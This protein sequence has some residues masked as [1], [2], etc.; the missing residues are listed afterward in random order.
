MKIWGVLLLGAPVKG[1]CRSCLEGSRKLR[2]YI[3]GFGCTVHSLRHVIC[4]F[5]AIDR[6][7]LLP[8]RGIETRNRIRATALELRAGF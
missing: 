7:K 5:Q 2:Q 8:I 4:S 6:P 3:L 1:V